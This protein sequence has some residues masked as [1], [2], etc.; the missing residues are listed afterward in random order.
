MSM[1]HISYG[2]NKPASPNLRSETAIVAGVAHATLKNSRTPWL[3][4]VADYNLI[5][6][7]IARVLPDFSGY[8]ERIQKPGGF[9]LPVPSGERI[10]T[11]SSGKAQF[12]VHA[13]PRDLPIQPRV[14]ISPIG[15]LAPMALA[16]SLERA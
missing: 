6:D 5:R 4:Y 15:T 2:M 12:L 10:W 7:D 9:R 13:I 14:C 1:V 3:Q 16:T 11:T 8:N